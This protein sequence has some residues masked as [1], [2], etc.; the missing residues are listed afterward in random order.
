MYIK[1]F[2]GK[3][4]HLFPLRRY[5]QPIINAVHEKKGIIRS[6]VSVMGAQGFLYIKK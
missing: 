4:T 1:D 2:Y 3:Y 6:K 5:W